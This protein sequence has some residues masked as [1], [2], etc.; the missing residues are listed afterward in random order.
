VSGWAAAYQ[1]GVRFL[2]G[3]R[4]PVLLQ[5]GADGRIR[6][7]SGIELARERLPE[8]D[9]ITL[10]GVRFAAALRTA[11]DGAR[12]RRGLF[13]AVVHLDMMLAAGAVALEGMAAY[14]DEHAGWPRV[15]QARTALDLADPR[16]A[17]PPETRM[18]LIWIL[19]AGLPRPLVNCPLF[20]LDGRLLGFPDAF[21]PESATALEYDSDDHR[22]LDYHT[23]DNCREELLEDHGAVVCRVTRLDM[24]RSLQQLIIRMKRARA[25]GLARDRRRDRWT[26]EPPPGWRDPR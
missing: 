3:A 23:A 7:R 26:L 9:V 8:S 14:W 13:E 6:K 21:D 5:L 1:Q 2:D 22:E 19:R 17:S 24:S 25:R 15:R 16:S 12:T 4:R 10:D 18:R 11:F 20:D